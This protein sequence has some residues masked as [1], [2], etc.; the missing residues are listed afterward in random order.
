[1]PSVEAWPPRT[2]MA[3]PPPL[4]AEILGAKKMRV[5]VLGALFLL[6][7][8]GCGWNGTQET[9]VVRIRVVQDHSGRAQSTCEASSDSSARFTYAANKVKRVEIAEMVIVI[10]VDSEDIRRL[11]EEAAALHKFLRTQVQESRSVLAGG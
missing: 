4:D 5:I 1:M 7:C 8:G 2:I 9:Q 3:P 10:P 11:V 6:V